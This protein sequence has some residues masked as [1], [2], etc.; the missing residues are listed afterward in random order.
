MF[1]LNS[2][3]NL[4]I[5]L[6][7][8]QTPKQLEAG[9]ILGIF[10]LPQPAKY[11]V[12]TSLV[13]ALHDRGHEITLIIRSTNQLHVYANI[14]K[15]VIEDQ[16]QIAK[17]FST[18]S[19]ENVDQNLFTK[20]QTI[21][22]KGARIN[23]NIFNNPEVR[24]IMKNEKFDMIMLDTFMT[25][26]LYGL[27]E[28]FNASMVGISNFG[29][30][31]SLDTMVGNV[32]PLSFIPSIFIQHT[33][34]VTFWQRCLNVALYVVDIMTYEFIH[35]PLQRTIY[36]DIF[37]N[38][39]LTFD[40][41]CRNF[42][43]VLLNQHFSLSFPRPYVP[44][45]IEVAG[46]HIKEELDR[47]P[48]SVQQFLDNSPQGVIYFYL[49]VSEEAFNLN[50]NNSLMVLQ[51]LKDLNYNII[52]NMDYMPVKARKFS[53]ILQVHN[54]SHY[55]ILAHAHVKLFI[56]NGELLSVIDA[57]YYAKPILGLPMFSDQHINIYMAIKNGYGLGLNLKQLHESKLKQTILELLNNSR[58]TKNIKELSDVFHDQP[59]KPLDKSIYWL[60]YVLRRKG[61]KHLRVKGRFLNF[62][63]FYNIDVFLAFLFV[64]ALIVFMIWFI[65]KYIHLLL[66]R[67]KQN[68]QTKFKRN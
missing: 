37:P 17:E 10:A 18:F 15:I 66:H 44:N 45:M 50:P 9:R 59:M 36:E 38:A 35:M 30:L 40:Q 56:T 62:W 49:G 67:S 31:T 24:E 19:S 29:S 32:S 14:R 34:E 63:Q 58:Y 52:W 46:L 39:T 8:W 7:L 12:T 25:E 53:N 27:G 65:M 33:F 47:L 43:L 60:E 23:S 64:F 3:I 22:G 13:N 68:L 16:E 61:A 57:V 5:V 26:A 51:T 48:T 2:I 4:L 20:M 28:Y 1:K 42:A 54:V 41:A 11:T 55:S 21:F 6:Y